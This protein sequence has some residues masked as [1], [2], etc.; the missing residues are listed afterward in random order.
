MNKLTATNIVQLRWQLRRISAAVNTQLS[1]QDALEH[2]EYLSDR[3]FLLRP[4]LAQLP[5]SQVVI[6]LYSLME[7]LRRL[8]DGPAHQMMERVRE[9]GAMTNEWETEFIQSY[10]KITARDELMKTIKQLPDGDLAQLEAGVARQYFIG[11]Y[12]HPHLLDLL[13]RFEAILGPIPETKTL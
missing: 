1:V 5:T 6:S 7:M 4:Y 2:F 8:P 12:Q 3:V 13:Q 9:L 10:T 11:P